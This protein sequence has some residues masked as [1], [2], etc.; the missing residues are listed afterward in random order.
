MGRPPHS[1]MVQGDGLAA[2]QLVDRRGMENSPAPEPPV[3]SWTVR[4]EHVPDSVRL[5]S[6][7]VQNHLALASWC[8]KYR[9]ELCS[10]CEMVPPCPFEPRGG[11]TE[12]HWG[13]QAKPTDLAVLFGRFGRVEAVNLKRRG[14]AL[15]NMQVEHDAEA[16]CTALQRTLMMGV[17]LLMSFE[18]P[19]SRLEVRA[20][21]PS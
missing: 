10:P 4:V 12:C 7:S 14:L 8:F 16:A 20:A 21:T 2:T 3:H 5:P 19:S 18:Q 17:P 11:R 13:V 9:T 1:A 15:V 6:T